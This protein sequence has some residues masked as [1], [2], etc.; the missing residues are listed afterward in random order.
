MNRLGLILVL[1]VV[2]LYSTL[3]GRFW[4][5]STHPISITAKSSKENKL[6]PANS[7]KKSRN[8]RF[9]AKLLPHEDSSYL[10]EFHS[11]N[12]DHCEQMEP[13]LQRLEDDLGTKIRRVNIFRRREF[14]GLME[15]MGHNECGGLPF[16]YNRRTGQA[17]CGATSYKNLKRWGTGDLK[18]LFQDPPEN[19]FEQEVDT[20]KKRSIGTKGFLQE[21]IMG[22]EKKGKEKAEKET[23]AKK[24]REGEESHSDNE[25]NSAN[26]RL[27]K[28]R[29]KKLQKTIT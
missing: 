14:Y 20:S 16:Y 29:R 8:N 19:M 22:I 17:I 15:S 11:D 18:T 2:N 23:A 6:S 13:V 10:I 12:C 25:T 7:S 24:N 27:E 3:G 1:I 4:S 9:L 28:R 21:K 5:K 26:S